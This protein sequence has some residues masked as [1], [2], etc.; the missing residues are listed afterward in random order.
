[1]AVVRPFELVLN[2]HTVVCPDSFGDDVSREAVDGHLDF[3]RLQ[4]HADGLGQVID[5]LGEP[6]REVPCL[7]RPCIAGWGVGEF[8][9]V[10]CGQMKVLSTV[11][12]VGQRTMGFSARRSE[13][14]A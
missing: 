12:R 10:L 5:I 13:L 8:G 2:Q 4:F 1:M 11:A 9:E 6:W 3:C 7:V 14:T